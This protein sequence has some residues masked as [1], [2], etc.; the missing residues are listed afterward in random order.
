MNLKA[1]FIS[2]FVFIYGYIQVSAEYW[3]SIGMSSV[4]KTWCWFKKKNISFM[5][6]SCGC[7]G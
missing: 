5:Y 7:Y 4:K 1:G 6:F 3:K 2:C